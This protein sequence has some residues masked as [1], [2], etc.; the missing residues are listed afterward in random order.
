MAEQ[1]HL[2]YLDRYH[3][4]DPLFL[5]SLARGLA[6]SQGRLAPCL[7]FHGSDERAERLL[8]G[9]G[10]FPERRQGVLAVHSVEEAVLVERAIRTS[11]Q[12]LVALLTDALVSA[13]GLHG[14]DR[15]L[16]RRSDDALETTGLEW[17][18]D[19]GRKGVVPVVSSLLQDHASGQ[20]R[21]VA[22]VE[23]VEAVATSIGRAEA[24]IV[25]FTTTNLPG[26]MDGQTPRPLVTLDDL[27]GM[28]VLP[29]AEAVG[30]LSSAGFN[31][32]LTNTTR[33]ADPGGPVG[34]RVYG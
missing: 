18:L 22:L 29:D 26:V 24:T 16:L 10:L 2:L 14:T 11:N 20:V 9:E 19:L 15:N 13:V 5:Q 17:V 1:T 25:F 3:M 4:G 32:L 27:D 8:E 12:K 6:R 31:V 21:E 7:L 34:T 23:A 28:E 30:R 33:L